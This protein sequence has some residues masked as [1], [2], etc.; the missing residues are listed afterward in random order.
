[1]ILSERDALLVLEAVDCTI[2]PGEVQWTFRHRAAYSRGIYGWTN[3]PRKF[4]DHFSVMP[5]DTI[6]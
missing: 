1:M 6:L 5:R 4:D 3:L 2:I